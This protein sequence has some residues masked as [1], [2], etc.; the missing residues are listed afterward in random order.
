MT[1]PRAASAR[2]DLDNLKRRLDAGADRA[3]TQ[4]CFDNDLF[5]GFLDRAPRAG[6]STPITAGIMPVTKFA[7]IARFAA[8]CGASIP[9]WMPE[10]FADLDEAPEIRD[11]IAATVAAEQ[12][13]HLLEHGVRHFHFYTLNRPEVSL[14]VCHLLGV[15]AAKRPTNQM[16]QVS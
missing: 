6:I 16:S 8:T 12:C 14:A 4:F 11:M 15:R 5:L 1:H 2:A 3:V 9:A 10:L 7:S 13:R